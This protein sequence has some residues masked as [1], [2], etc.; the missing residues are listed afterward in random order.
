M[1]ECMIVPNHSGNASQNVRCRNRDDADRD[2]DGD[3]DHVEV[4][5]VVDPRTSVRMPLAATEPNST[6]PGPAE[7][8]VGDRGD[9][10]ADHRQQAEQEQDQSARGHGDTGS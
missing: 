8:R 7:D 3:D 2:R 6:M 1:P 9:D 5:V 10:G 4:V